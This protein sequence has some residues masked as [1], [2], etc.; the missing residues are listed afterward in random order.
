[1]PYKDQRS[2]AVLFLVFIGS[3]FLFAAPAFIGEAVAIIGAGVIITLMIV[4][5]YSKSEEDS[6]TKEKRK[7]EHPSEKISSL[8]GR[9]LVSSFLADGSYFSRFKGIKKWVEE[10]ENDTSSGEKE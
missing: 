10:W 6:Y 8:N 3:L 2:I 5:S 7:I 4:F 9:R 1:M